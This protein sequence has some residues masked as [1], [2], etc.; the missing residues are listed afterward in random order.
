[1]IQ[2]AQDI[3]SKLYVKKRRRSELQRG[4]LVCTI[5]EIAKSRCVSYFFTVSYLNSNKYNMCFSLLFAPRCTSAPSRQKLE[6]CTA[7]FVSVLGKIST[8]MRWHR[9]EILTTHRCKTGGSRI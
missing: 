6:L 2:I 9:L 8:A 1:M 4:F 5:G 7:W 3:S